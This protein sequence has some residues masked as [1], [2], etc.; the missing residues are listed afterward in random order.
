VIDILIGLSP[1]TTF[2]L[3]IA[4]MGVIYLADRRRRRKDREQVLRQFP[5]R[6]RKPWE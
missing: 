4:M 1:L 5:I 2:G 6:H 3:W